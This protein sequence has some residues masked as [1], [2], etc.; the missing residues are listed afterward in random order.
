MGLRRWSVV[1]LGAFAFAQVV[2]IGQAL[3]GGAVTAPQLSRYPYLTDLVGTAVTVNWGTD[4][5]ATVASAQWGAV[6]GTG[7]CAPTNSVAI[8]GR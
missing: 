8:F 4:R 2:A 5:S 3:P 6:D 1:V 7:A